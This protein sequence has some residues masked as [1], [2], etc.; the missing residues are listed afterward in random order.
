MMSLNILTKIKPM[1]WYDEPPT[2]K[3]KDD[4]ITVVSGDNTDFWRKTHY[5]FIRDTGHFWYQEVSGNFQATVK[6]VGTYETLYDQAGLM[7]RLDEK[8]WL[9]CGIEFV[10]GGQYASVVVTRDYS[11]WSVVTIPE[12]PVAFWLRLQR[13]KGAV[14]V[15]YSRDGESYNLL[16]MAY[17]TEEDKVQVGLM[18]A[19][20][21]RGGFQVEFQEFKIVPLLS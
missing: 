4:S 6:I 15:K 12:N 19:S 10:D 5:G 2:W 7:I 21:Q 8:I 9:K 13:K 17:L 14:E 16:R 11:D 1:Q 18:C 20:P 3:Q